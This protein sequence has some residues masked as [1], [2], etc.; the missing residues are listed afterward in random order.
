MKYCYFNKPEY[1]FYVTN[2]TLEKTKF[3]FTNKGYEEKQSLAQFYNHIPKDKEITIVDIGAQSGLYTLFAKYLPLADYHSFEPFPDSYKLLND[4]IQLNNITNVQ[5]Y[6]MALSN[7][8]G[9]TTL[10]TCISHTGLHTLGNN[11]TRFKD[12]KTIE[13]EVS[14][15]DKMFFDKNIKVDFIKIDT[16]GCE[17]NIIKGGLQTI[18]KYKPTIQMEWYEPN[19]KQFNISINQLNEL[20]ISL[21][22]KLIAKQK[23][24]YLFQYKNIC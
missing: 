12:V 8:E 19:L 3:T 2:E 5:T 10:N 15:L 23:G 16:E 21:D 6:N 18:K 24:E 11:L 9:K 4:N 13:V 17:Y 22:Y 20:L 1:P 14:T 7:I